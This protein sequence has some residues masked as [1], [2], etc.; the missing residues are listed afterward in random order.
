MVLSH[1]LGFPSIG[2]RRQTKFTIEKF[3]KGELSK[4]AL[5]NELAQI[6]KNNWELQKKLGIEIVPSND[7]SA[8]D[9]MLDLACMVNAIPQRY[10]DL[11][12][13]VEQYFSMARGNTS[14]N[15]V[16]MDM[17]KWFD[18]NYHYIVP[19]FSR[20]ENFKFTSKKI[21]KEYKEAL[22]AGIKTKPVL[23]DP[24]T[25]LSLGKEKEK[26]K[27][28][29]FELLN[30]LISVYVEVLTE[31]NVLGADYIQIDSPVL[32]TD[33]SS[34]QKEA[35]KTFQKTLKQN[36]SLSSFKS[37]IILATYFGGIEHN[38]DMVMETPIWDILHIDLV[39]APQQ[40]ESVLSKLPSDKSLS[41]GLVD[42]RNIWKNDLTR[43][44]ELASKALSK[45]G[46]DRLF[47]APSC[48][49]QHVP[50][51]L[52]LEEKLD[53]AIKAW[54]SF[55]V[56]K[57]EEVKVITECLN[58]SAS[59]ASKKYLEENKKACQSRKTS[60]LIHKR[61]VKE[62]LN[63]LSE[64]NFKRNSSFAERKT[65]QVK[66]LNLGL[67]PTTTIGSFPQTPELRQARAKFKNKELSEAEYNEFLKKLTKECVEWQDSIGLD[68]LVH[69]EFERTDMVEYFGDF[70]T[71]FATTSN[72]WV[73]SYGSRCVKPPVI[74][75]D[76]S[77]KAPMALDWTKYA[78]SLT[79]KY[80]KGMLTGPVT[81]LGWSFVRDDQPDSQTAMQI[82]LAIRDEV[83]DLEKAGIKIIQIDEPAFREGL[84][85]RDAEK[86]GYLN[87]AT[88]AF[89]L[90][91]SSVSDETQ[92]HTHM[93]YSDFNDIIAN[94][95]DMD[96][97][98]ITIET[99]RSD[100]D[101][102]KAFEIFEYP[103][104]VGP[105]VYDIHSPRIPTENEML[106]LME[107]ACNLIPKENLWVNPDCGLKTRR[108]EE[109]KP[110][111]ENMI[112]VAKKMRQKLTTKKE[113]MS[114]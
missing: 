63:K 31:L 108:W 29:K 72:G 5:F 61:E 16:A 95:A 104:E 79:K 84:P 94:I 112:S 100:M 52:S 102:L 69:G 54:M 9:K 110:A 113:A 7:F 114:N 88:R 34:E 12:D 38:L 11:S 96:A 27:F 91:S 43:S 6:R 80:M 25:F 82:A 83:S 17:T 35:Y 111:L 64:E 44:I 19:E 22:D 66:A 56:Q 70:L 76:V 49:L 60:E 89:R 98:V 24:V 51:D 109:V 77:R 107:K 65:V 86:S 92:I 18:T 90:S 41:L 57:L 21:L 85:L 105:G 47:I 28:N 62:R 93:C 39:R 106:S 97:D 14:K 58:N 46:S 36:L 1:N 8:Y 99:S 73:Q 10:R 103:N 71:G 55:A 101:L 53:P 33:L 2:E 42:G 74:F 78:Q 45:I 87:W 4:E 59:E 37:K 15:L 81:I 40:L 48:S 67:L 30:S 32:V 3:W 50:V 26:E 23:I 75:G 13:D 68:V 20:N